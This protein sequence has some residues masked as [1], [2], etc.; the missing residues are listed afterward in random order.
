MTRVRQSG[1]MEAV[2]ADH[3][4]IQLA[5]RKQCGKFRELVVVGR[6]QSVGPCPV[7]NGG[8]RRGALPGQR[9]G[10]F[11]QKLL[12]IRELKEYLNKNGVEMRL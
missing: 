4:E 7:E 5:L 10:I 2:A 11:H 9:T 6:E 1:Q 12:T 8:Q 3:R